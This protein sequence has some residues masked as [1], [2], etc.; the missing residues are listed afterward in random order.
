M[1]LAG[2]ARNIAV[3]FREDGSFSVADDGA[4]ISLATGPGGLSVLERVLTE[5]RDSPTMDGHH[6]DIHL[7][8]GVGLAP[9]NALSESLTVQVTSDDGSFEQSFARGHVACGCTTGRPRGRAGFGHDRDS[10]P[11]QGDLRRIHHGEASDLPSL[12][13][14]LAGYPSGPVLEVSARDGASRADI[15]LTFSRGHGPRMRTF[16]NF[17]ELHEGGLTPGLGEG[18]RRI[19][20]ER[21]TALQP[22]LTAVIHVVL[23]DPA[24]GGPTRTR[25]DSPEAVELVASALAEHLPA[26]L[27]SHPGL[28]E[29]LEAR[30]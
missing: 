11:R 30:L 18:L 20:G 17:R 16:C 21:W 29:E 19:F 2:K 7:G 9:V 28:V 27:A 26:A 15:A 22:G 4:C 1:C 23:L 8:F 14:E 25:L 12:V 5:V 24:F 10:A 3:T 13:S 6:P